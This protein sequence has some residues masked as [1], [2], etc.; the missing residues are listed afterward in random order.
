ML[1][2]GA[3]GSFL[4]ALLSHNSIAVTCI[5]KESTA[6]II[7]KDGIRFESVAF[8]NFV[9]RPRAITYLDF[10]PDILFV[11]TKATTLS[12]ALKRIEPRFVKNTIIIPLLNGIEHMEVLR[13]SYGKQ[14]VAGS[15]GNIEVKRLSPNHIIHSTRSAHIELASNGG[16][17]IDRLLEVVQLLSS[18]GIATKL[19]KSEA[20]VLWGKLVR[21]NALACTTSAS[22]QPIGF[23]RSDKWW[24]R[25]LEGCVKEAAAVVFAEGVEINSRAVMD[26]IDNLPPDIGTS[27]QRD[28]IAGKPSELDA[29]AGAVVREGAKHG[30]DC[31]VIK[32]LISMIQSRIIT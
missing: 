26:Q 22:N 19:L 18:V 8:G 25:Q 11:T 14:V 10:E 32:G 24:R 7:S 17:Q 23:I 20:E 13:S 1:G 4:V 15:I 29:I 5:A 30:L 16:I 31:P 3:V 28:I 21:L 2:P 12:D 27:M 9:V 6:E